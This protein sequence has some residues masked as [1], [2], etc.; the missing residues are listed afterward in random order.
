MTAY[1]VEVSE[2]DKISVEAED[3][4]VHDIPGLI[5]NLWGAL[6]IVGGHEAKRSPAYQQ[7]MGD[8][9]AFDEIVADIH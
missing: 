2:D 3:L 9:R 5:A 4:S 8:D 7:I 6:H 1:S